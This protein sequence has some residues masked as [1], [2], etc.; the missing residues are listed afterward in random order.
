MWIVTIY[1]AILHGP[2]RVY[3]YNLLDGSREINKEFRTVIDAN[4]LTW[5]IWSDG[6]TVWASDDA[7]DALYAYR[8]SDGAVQINKGFSLDVS[9]SQRLGVWS[10]GA[11]VWIL[12]QQNGNNIVDAYRLADGARQN[13]KNINVVT[14]STSLWSD[15]KTLWVADNRDDKIYTYPLPR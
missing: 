12:K 10:D 1:S 15:G 6:E 8:L 3:A 14:S 13:N 2:D 5:G 9:T 4:M 7:S 11:T